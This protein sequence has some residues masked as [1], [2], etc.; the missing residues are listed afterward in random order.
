MGYKNLNIHELRIQGI[1][2]S[3]SKSRWFSSRREYVLLFTEKKRKKRFSLRKI[4]NKV[5]PICKVFVSGYRFFHTI[6][7]IIKVVQNF[8]S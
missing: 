3:G 1:W 7:D 5:L 2:H 6:L 8:L 4:I